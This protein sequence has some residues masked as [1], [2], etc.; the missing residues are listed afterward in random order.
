MAGVG[1]GGLLMM[2]VT[3]FDR[4]LV[5]AP[6]N[7]FCVLTVASP[8]L[9]IRDPGIVAE[10]ME[11]STLPAE[12]FA[13]VVGNFLPFHSMNVCATNP[14]PLI[15]SVKSPLPAGILDG[16]KKEIE[17]PVLPWKVLP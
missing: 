12:S 2:K 3:V 11:P 15:V 16:D 9:A 1:F 8:G 5:P 4:P 13:T 6:E 17:A 7:G 14:A 10:T